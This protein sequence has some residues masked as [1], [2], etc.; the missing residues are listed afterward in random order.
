MNGGILVNTYPAPAWG[1]REIWRYA[2]CP[3]EDAALSPL[4]HAC[5]AEI[6]PQLSYRVAYGEFPVIADGD[7]LHIGAVS[8]DS[9]LLRRT[10]AGCGS[11]IVIAGTVGLSPDRLMRR[12][13]AISPTKSVFF[14]AIGA[15]R[16]EALMDAASADIANG[17]ILTPRV[18]P[19]YGD[20]PLALQADIVA[21]LRCPDT[22]GLTLT[23][24][25]LMSP[26]KSVTAF[27]G[28]KA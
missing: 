28:V 3:A 27:I 11:C 22:I 17:R 25:L 5:M 1:E 10:L 23:D 14:Q 7:T 8:T 19:G 16:I 6:E 12:Y 13:S 15:E 4:L 18:S 9:T 2:G 24:S 21:A 26:T 20:I